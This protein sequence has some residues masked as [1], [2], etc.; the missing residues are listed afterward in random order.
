MAVLGASVVITN[1][2][3][4]NKVVGGKR[5]AAASED[6]AAAEPLTAKKRTCGTCGQSGHDKRNCSSKNV[7]TPALYS[8]V[9]ETDSTFGD[10]SDAQAHVYNASD[11]WLENLLADLH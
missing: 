2:R 4:V 9:D 5:K 1:N 8:D 10:S 6:K 3:I 11:E 7:I